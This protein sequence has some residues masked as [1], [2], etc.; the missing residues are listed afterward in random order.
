MLLCEPMTAT[1]MSLFYE[2]TCHQR[3]F[4]IS[5]FFCHSGLSGI[6]QGLSGRI[7]DALRLRE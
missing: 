7:P 6:I 3:E 1:I 5:H 4:P 2:T